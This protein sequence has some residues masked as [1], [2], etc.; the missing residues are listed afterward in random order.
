MTATTVAPATRRWTARQA[1]YKGR[2][3]LHV[4]LPD[5]TARQYVRTRHGLVAR[6]W[7]GLGLAEVVLKRP[8]NKH[9]TYQGSVRIVPGGWQAYDDGGDRPV[10][11][12]PVCTDYLDAEAQLLP[13]RTG[14]RASGRYP[15]LSG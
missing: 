15:C 4:P 3:T 2:T 14:R 9:A 12:G 13:R 1:G 8:R 10:P 5:G 11:V 6:T 7:V